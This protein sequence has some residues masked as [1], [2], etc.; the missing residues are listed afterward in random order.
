MKKYVGKNSDGLIIVYL[1][2]ICAILFIL[3][4]ILH[5]FLINKGIIVI[6]ILI[7]ALFSILVSFNVYEGFL[8]I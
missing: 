6:K 4:F 7:F 8:Y 3:T 2:M 5:Q 1:H